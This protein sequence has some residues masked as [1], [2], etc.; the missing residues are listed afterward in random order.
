MTFYIV[1]KDN[2]LA[3]HGIYESS[4]KAEKFIKETVPVYVSRGY[5]MNKILTKDSF[6]V[7]ERG[8]SCKSK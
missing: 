5:Y 8:A 3:I 2:H 4:E 7:I 1:E 6:E